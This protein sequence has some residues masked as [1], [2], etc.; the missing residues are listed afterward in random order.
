MS[1]VQERKKKCPVTLNVSVHAQKSS[2][3]PEDTSRH[4]AEPYI[5]REGKST[6][7]PAGRT[8]KS[9]AKVMDTGRASFRDVP[10]RQTHPGP[11]LRRAPPLA[12]CSA[13]S[14]VRSLINFCH[15]APNFNFLLGPTNYI[16]RL[17]YGGG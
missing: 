14:C 10:P 13:V 5:S 3:I 8:A 16:A 2:L 6:L 7:L 1:E 15:G 12:E 4:M 17:E 9:Y 11:T